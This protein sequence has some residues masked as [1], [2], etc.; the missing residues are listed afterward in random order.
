MFALVTVSNSESN[1]LNIFLNLLKIY[2]GENLCFLELI[3]QIIHHRQQ[4]L[5]LDAHFIKNP[6]FL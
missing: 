2:F 4:I 6:S 5:I 1:I 3:K